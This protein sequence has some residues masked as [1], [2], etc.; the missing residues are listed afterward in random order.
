MLP[1]AVA[2]LVSAMPVAIIVRDLRRHGAI[3]IAR[4]ATL[5]TL[6]FTVAYA[7]GFVVAH[8][9]IDDATG[10][11]GAVAVAIVLGWV[12]MGLGFLA[13]ARVP[14]PRVTSAAPGVMPARWMIIGLAVIGLAATI[15]YFVRIGGFPLFMDDLEQGRVD[16]A[17]VGGGTLRTLSTLLLPAAWLAVCRA[18]VLGRE[19][20][21][22]AGAVALAIGS[23]LL[24][25]NRSLA[26]VALMVAIL[27]ILLIRGHHRASP[28]QALA[29]AMVALAF[30]LAAGA[31]GAYRYARSPQ[32]WDVDPQIGRAAAR[33]DWVALGTRAIRDYLVVP[34]YNLRLTMAAVPDRIPFQLGGT[35]VQPL[36]TALP[37]HQDTFD[38][39][40]KEALGQDYPGGGTVPGWVGEGWANF[41]WLGVV[42]WPMVTA[43]AVFVLYRVAADGRDPVLWTLYAYAL[44]HL[45]GGLVGGLFVASVFPFVA[46]GVL[47]AAVV[48]GRRGARHGSR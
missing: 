4:P 11:A 41:G 36:L 40:L 21:V 9:L 26:I 38:A 29:L 46:Y 14:A 15:A 3:H 34:S 8:P 25:G 20:A 30:V 2:V 1:V 6:S 28:R 12:G 37:G 44:L 16:A 5:V 31:L 22:A 7:I 19:R 47:T 33:G 42:L 13:G 35:V 48:L 10:V 39:D 32:V 23:Q 27:A 45:S 43:A 17:A 24:T 18:S